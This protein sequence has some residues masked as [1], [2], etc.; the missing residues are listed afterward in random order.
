MDTINAFHDETVGNVAE[1]ARFEAPNRLLLARIV[2]GQGY[3]FDA[4]HF[5]RR[6]PVAVDLHKSVD[7][8]IS[9]DFSLNALIGI[10]DQRA[11]T[12]GLGGD[13]RGQNLGSDVRFQ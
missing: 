12:L 2:P 10:D 6:A 11:L 8:A 1:V 5:A 4:R 7:V 3:F 13:R 9:N